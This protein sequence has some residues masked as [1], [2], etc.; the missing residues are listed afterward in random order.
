MHIP[1]VGIT[2]TDMPVEHLPLAIGSGSLLVKLP[3][4]VVGLSAASTEQGRV[5]IYIANATEA[6]ALTRHVIQ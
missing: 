2:S 6:V 4:Q 5:L 3:L 1:L